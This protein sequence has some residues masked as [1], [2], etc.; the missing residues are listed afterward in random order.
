MRQRK[1]KTKILTLE[2]KKKKTI[3]TPHEKRHAPR[4][5]THAM[6]DLAAGVNKI[7][8]LQAKRLKL[9]EESEKERR[10]ERKNFLKFC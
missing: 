10:K 8:E 2:V 1:V 6:R 4:S 9:E 7:F 3:I 5:Q